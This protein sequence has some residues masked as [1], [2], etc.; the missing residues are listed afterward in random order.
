[1][2]TK[3]YS[4]RLEGLDVP[5]GE[6]S[7]RDISELGAALQQAATRIARQIAGAEGRG[8]SSA[9]IDRLSELRLTGL[10]IGSTVLEMIVGDE[11]T[12]R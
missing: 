9:Y 11:A 1:M 12:S 5:D 4:L 7:F 3:T 8:R 2:T 6:I 10:G